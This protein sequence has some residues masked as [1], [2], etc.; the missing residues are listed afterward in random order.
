[1]KLSDR[2]SGAAIALFGVLVI[3]GASQL[4][5]IHGVRFG[6]DLIPRLIG[7]ALVGLGGIIAIA[8][9]A[10][11]DQAT[12][13]DWSEWDV[14]TR[15]KLA[16]LWS[17]LG[18]VLGGLLFEFVGFPLLGIIYMSGLMALMGAKLKVIAT[19]APSTVL[20]LYF[21]F[22]KG[23]LVPLPVGFLGDILP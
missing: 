1:M 15:D 21:G 23:L 17:L 14:P 12:L 11:K 10:A 8:G 4:P 16:A 20:A 9:F 22:S 7:I 13:I 5:T 18:L 3:V 6:A 2:I 19:I